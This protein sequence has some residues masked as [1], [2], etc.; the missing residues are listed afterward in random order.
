MGLNKTYNASYTSPSSYRK[1]E[2]ELAET[3]NNDGVANNVFLVDRPVEQKNPGSYYPS[4]IS[5]D[6][7]G[8]LPAN[9]EV[10]YEVDGFDLYRRMK[11]V[12]NEQAL[13]ND[14]K[15]VKWCMYIYLNNEEIEIKNGHLNYI[16][17]WGNVK[18]GE[19]K[20][21]SD[22]DFD[23]MA[24]KDPQRRT[25]Y[26]R[27]YALTY[28][29]IY[30]DTEKQTTK[31]AIKFSKWL[32]GYDVCI[33]AYRGKPDVNLEKKYVIKRTV[34]AEPEIIKGFWT[35]DKKEDITNRVVG[36]KDTIY[37]CVETLGIQ[38]KMMRLELWDDDII[39]E[40][41]DYDQVEIQNAEFKIAGRYTYKKIELP[42]ES[43]KGFKNM[44]GVLEGDDLELFFKL[45]E[46]VDTIGYEEKFGFTLTLTTDERISNAYFAQQVTQDEVK[47]STLSTTS[48]G[49]DKEKNTA[50]E[51][52][53]NTYQKIDSATLGSEV[54]IV[55]ETANLHGK[56]VDIE[57]FDNEALLADNDYTPI[58]LIK[59]GAEV[60][61][62]EQILI[63][64]TGKAVIKVQ[65]RPDK[66]DEFKKLKNKFTDDKIAKLFLKVQCKGDDIMH[67]GEFMDEDE[68]EVK[69]QSCC[70]AD[71]TK[72]QLKKIA[73]HAADTNIDKHLSGLNLAFKD[74]EI[75]TCLRRIHFLAQVIHESGSFRYTREANVPDTA[76]GG[77]PGRG[78]MQLTGKVNYEKYGAFASEDVT[79]SLENK[80]KIE[81]NPHASKSAGW[82][83]KEKADLN[84]NADEN[85]FIYITRIIN[86]GFNGYNDRLLY[87]SRGFKE[88]YDKCASKNDKIKAK[89]SFND[90]KAYNDKRASFAWGLWHD[91]LAG[92]S[93]CTHDKNKAIAGYQRFID[94]TPSDYSETNWYLIK[95]ISLFSSLKKTLTIKGKKYD[96][97][98]VREAAKYRLEKLKAE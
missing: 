51:L 48:D 69:D 81:K 15:H 58:K 59:D 87:V 73:N 93:G 62:L 63:D 40:D 8:V 98:N 75:N 26:I 52:S 64:D 79:S 14:K 16:D 70:T 23:F 84:D 77:Y 25:D 35:N 50:K 82:F 1:Y 44:R 43:D 96:K 60:S 28:L 55:V 91:P 80:K 29:K 68:F 66:E 97:V 92:K 46:E 17:L 7:S 74:C 31:L 20:R 39:Y 95:S 37:A 56:K 54:W 49:S 5:V 76:Y 42:S 30:G 12:E 24:I 32:D 57:V 45:P 11:G 38:G 88:L 9:K 53:K 34:V 18:L 71:I 67:S 47:D 90:S 6:Q 94:L 3:A 65:L 27:R 36:Y 72:E 2:A 83:W 78:L 85:D 22:C 86:G 89:Y 21:Q 61:K 10:I 13:I 4:S 19:P 41:K 33:E